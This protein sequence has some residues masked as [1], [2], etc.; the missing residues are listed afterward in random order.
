M[1]FHPT[2]GRP[3]EGPEVK[4]KRQIRGKD[5]VERLS[6]QLKY[7]TNEDIEMM[8]EVMKWLG[9]QY[10][11]KTNSPDRNKRFGLATWILGSGVHRSYDSIRTIKDNIRALQKQNLLQQDQIIIELSHYLKITYGHISSN[12]HA[13]TNSQVSVINL[14]FLV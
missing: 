10:M 4:L 6:E 12:R 2:L 3:K 13:I 5:R 7:I 11:D 14:I 1:E 9:I 8:R